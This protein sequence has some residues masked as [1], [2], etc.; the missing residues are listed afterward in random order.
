[1]AMIETPTQRVAAPSSPAWR[2]YLVEP[3]LAV[4]R[5]ARQKPLGGLA[6]FIIF[7][8][9]I[10]AVFEPLIVPFD[11][12]EARATTTDPV[13]G[14][15]LGSAVSRPS[16]GFLSTQVDATDPA[17]G[18]TRRISLEEL[19]DPKT[20]AEAKE[21]R[22][23]LAFHRQKGHW[24]GTDA[25]GHDILSRAFRSAR[26]DLLIGFGAVAVGTTLGTLLGLISGYYRGKIEIVIQRF[27]DGLMAFPALV[28]I[29]AMGTIMRDR[30]PDLLVPIL[31][32]GLISIP[33]GARV[34]R[35][36]VL[37]IS[38]QVYIEAARASGAS[39]RRIIFFHVL[40]NV[41]APVIVIATVL[42]GAAIIATATLSFL[43]LGPRCVDNPSWGC[44]LTEGAPRFSTAPYLPLIPGLAIVSIVYAFNMLGDSLRDV[45]DPRL[46]GSGRRGGY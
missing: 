8:W 28:L 43:Q 6:L 38:N 4:V 24:L 39:N 46:R 18:I 37:S 13:T 25:A 19:R 31:A 11:P 34:V 14:L 12:I 40:P 17:T 42:I 5:F 41:A 35:G 1:M 29:L 15:R 10:I 44:M 21:K 26:T 27:V 9:A 33:G 20:A 30:V 45:L 23:S 36:T 16:F 3:L 7:A 32:I 22:F 2:R